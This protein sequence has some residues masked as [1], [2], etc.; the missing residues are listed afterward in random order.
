MQLFGLD[1]VQQEAVR[2]PEV[3]AI[4]EQ[5]LLGLGAVLVPRQVLGNALLGF[6]LLRLDLVIDLALH[7]CT[8]LQELLILDG[9]CGKVDLVPQ[10]A[11]HQ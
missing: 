6:L 4:L 5:L 1:T 9:L 7:I 3:H 11:Q 8:H 2:D 10:V